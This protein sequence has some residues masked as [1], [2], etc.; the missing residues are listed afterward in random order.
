M[1]RLHAIA[2]F[3]FCLVASVPQAFAIEDGERLKI[4]G[5]RLS[6]AVRVGDVDADGPTCSGMLITPYHVLTAAHCPARCAMSVLLGSRN[7]AGTERAIIE[8][9]LRHPGFV[10]SD[11]GDTIFDAKVV[12]LFTPLYPR[13]LRGRAKQN[14]RRELVRYGP[15]IFVDHRAMVFGYGITSEADREDGRLSD[16]DLQDIGYL[17]IGQFEVGDPAFLNMKLESLDARL[18]GGD[19]GAAIVVPSHNQTGVLEDYQIIGIVSTIKGGDAF[20]PPSGYIKR[21]VDA[22]VAGNH[23]PSLCPAAVSN[24]ATG[25]W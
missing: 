6:A 21:W 11:R 12:R 16:E 19:S 24:V 18:Q 15:Q 3:A 10:M 2:L 5:A 14:Y 17:R 22:V 20:G 13:D 9:S 1:H 8:G 23:A 7:E 25:T 4:A